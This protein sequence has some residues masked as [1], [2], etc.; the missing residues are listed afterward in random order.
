MKEKI[1]SDIIHIPDFEEEKLH[2][3]MVDTGNIAAGVLW[4]SGSPVKIGNTVSRRILGGLIAMVGID[5]IINLDDDNSAL[6]YVSKKTPWYHKM[7]IQK[8]VIG[9]AMGL[10]IPGVKSNEQKLKTALRFMIDNEW[11]YLI[12]CYYGVDRTGFVIAL[13]QALMGASLKEICKE[14]LSAIPFDNNDSS[15][16][17]YYRRTKAIMNQIKKMAHG[18]II[19]KINIQNAAEQ[20]LLHDIGLSQDEI[21][22][23]KNLL[24]GKS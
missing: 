19:T 13:L 2:I 11:P 9:L 15:K 1:K 8:K 4:R 18:E 3:D 17:E 20:Y 7:V 6:E 23:L 21:T 16:M 12:R 10:N 14:Y 22:K 24:A 5:C